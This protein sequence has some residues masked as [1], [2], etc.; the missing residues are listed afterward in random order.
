METKPI[1]L[2]VEALKFTLMVNLPM[3][4][5]KLFACL[6]VSIFMILWTINTTIAFTVRIFE[7]ISTFIF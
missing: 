2:G 6:I 5:A 7:T 1:K 3:F 4:M